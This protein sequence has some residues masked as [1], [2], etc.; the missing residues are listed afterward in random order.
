MFF[1]SIIFLGRNQSCVMKIKLV[2]HCSPHSRETKLAREASCTITSYEWMCPIHPLSCRRRV[3]SEH[4]V[5]YHV[6]QIQHLVQPRCPT[7]R[8]RTY[9]QS[10]ALPR[11][12]LFLPANASKW[13]TTSPGSSK[14]QS[15]A[16]LPS[17]SILTSS[18][19]SAPG[20]AQDDCLDAQ[21]P[22]LLRC[23]YS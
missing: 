23:P 18:T 13:P 9:S 10:S 15:P 1:V 5:I 11:S 21:A 4:Q 14:L 16:L 17:S 8:T 6:T 12:A 19:Q 3:I 22:A 2:T 20:K 7:P